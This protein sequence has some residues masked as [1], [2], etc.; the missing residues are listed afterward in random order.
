M[1][2]SNVAYSDN[3]ILP[4]NENKWNTGTFYN[5]DERWE[6]KVKKVSHK[7]THTVW[8]HLYKIPRR[9]ISTEKKVDQWL[10]GAKGREGSE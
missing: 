4:D 7:R 2:K 9:G 5:I 1:D 3:R 10:P 6:Y 8:F